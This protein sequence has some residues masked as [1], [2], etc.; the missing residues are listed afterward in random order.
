VV[1]NDTWALAILAFVE[2]SIAQKQ[3]NPSTRTLQPQK[4]KKLTSGEAR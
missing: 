1:A 4:G 3:S 2:G